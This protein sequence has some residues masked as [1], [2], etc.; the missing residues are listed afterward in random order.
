MRD[1]AS[2]RLSSAD[3]GAD[4]G[5]PLILLVEDDE[6]SVDLLSL[7]LTDAGFRVEVAGDGER[8]LE[9][10]RR[11]RPVGI[12]LDIILPGLDGWDLLAALKADPA[13]AGIPVIIV[14]MLDERGKGFALGAAEYLVKP[15]GRDDVLTALRRCIAVRGE[16]R[17]VLAID[18]DP[19]AIEMIQAVLRG[20]GFTVLTATG[21]EE[22]VA[23]ARDE[24]PEMVLLDLLMPD[25]DGFAVVERLRADPTTAA[26]PIVVLTAKDMTAVDKERLN[27]QISFLADKGEFDRSSL[28]DLVDRFSRVPSAG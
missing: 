17:K 26:I 6:H 22:G 7:H 25:V 23:A 8:G 13:V 28:V 24:R 9:L 3:I 21:G 18:D 15:V 16:G 12:V 2:P 4:D 19:L 1:P 27:G 5:R 14:S 11:L 10:A 20:E